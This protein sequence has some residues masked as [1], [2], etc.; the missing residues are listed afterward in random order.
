MWP[1]RNVFSEQELAGL[2]GFPE[3]GRAELIRYFTLNAAEEGFLRKF[4]GAR[5]VLG[6]GVP[7]CTLPWLGF[8]P[9]DV[10]VKKPHQVVP[11]DLREPAKTLQLLVREHLRD[12]PPTPDLKIQVRKLL[13]LISAGNWLS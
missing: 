4:L 6:A 12:Q 3:I 8:V 11:A 7:L 9:D 1:T 5:N 10:S 2:R 13:S